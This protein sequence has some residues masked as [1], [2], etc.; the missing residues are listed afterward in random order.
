MRSGEHSQQD[1]EKL[2]EKYNPTPLPPPPPPG[3]R[4]RDR[5]KRHGISLPTGVVFSKNPTIPQNMWKVLPHTFAAVVSDGQFKL[6]KHIVILSH[7]ISEALSRGGARLVIS[8]P[9]RHGKSWFISQ[10]L[11]AWYLA[12]W[13]EKRVILASYEANFAATW[14]RRVR[15]IVKDKGDMIG[16]TLAE[17]ST[18]TH[19]WATTQGGG[20]MTSGA[21]GALTGKGL[22]LGIIDDAHKNWQEAQSPTVRQNIKDWFDSTFMTR[23]EPGASVVIICTRWH[24]DDIIGHCLQMGG[25]THVRIPA[26]AEDSD[27]LLDR[28]PGSPLCPERYNLSALM[29]I[30][31]K[32]SSLMWNALYQQRPAPAEGS[33]F[34]RENWVYYKIPPQINFVLQS[35]DTASSKLKDAAYSVCQTWGIS[36]NHVVLLAQ[37]RDRVEYPQL[38]KMAEI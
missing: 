37:W 29:K 34:K 4:P 3:K 23:L 16:V 1:L 24:Q 8:I 12:N 19:N 22:D 31:S 20:M 38:R 14:G 27:D 10:W 5:A 6:Y 18:A 30:K 32:I 17:D 13:P 25:W 11:P 15:N 35:W 28:P 21:G 7:I 33:L 2:L 9:P 36:S 26:V